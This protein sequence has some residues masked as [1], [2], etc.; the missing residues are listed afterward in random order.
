MVDGTV[1]GVGFTFIL[2]RPFTIAAVTTLPTFDL[3]YVFIPTNDLVVM[4]WLLHCYRASDTISRTKAE[5]KAF[6]HC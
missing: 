4:Q 1:V 6:G 5:V 2:P 3:H